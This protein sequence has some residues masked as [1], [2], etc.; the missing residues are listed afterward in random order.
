MSA[1]VIVMSSDTRDF[2]QAVLHEGRR[3]INAY[4]WQLFNAVPAS[5]MTMAS[6]NTLSF[7]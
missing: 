5:S 4:S 3:D 1:T 2:T 7:M 6:K